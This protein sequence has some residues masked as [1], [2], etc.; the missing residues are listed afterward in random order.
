MGTASR[1]LAPRFVLGFVFLVSFALLFFVACQGEPGL[2]GPQG[3]KGDQGAQGIQGVQG[4]K[5]DPGAQGLQGLQG[6]AGPQG[7]QGPKGEPGE[8]A[9]IIAEGYS[10]KI[11]G[12]TIG[13]D[14]KPVVTFT[15]RDGKNQP[16]KLSDLDSNPG[17]IAAYIKED[18]ASGYTEYVNYITSAVTGSPYTFKGKTMQPVLGRITR[19]G[20]DSGGAFAQLAPGKY[21][22]TFKN[23]LPENYDATATHSIGM[24]TTR[25]AREF[26][27]N[28]VLDFVPAGGA[29]KTTRQIVNINNCNACHDKLAFHGGSRLDTKLCVLCHTSQN[30][31][32]ET[33][34]SVE[35]RTMV[36]RIHSGDR[37]QSVLSGTPYYIVGNRQT[38]FDFSGIGWPQDTRNC[39]TCHKD[40]PNADNYKNKP[41]VAACVS[42][43]EGIDP[44]KGEKHEV[45][46]PT[47]CGASCHKA[48]TGVEFDNSVVGA[49]VIP[50]A[51]SQL[52]GLKA[53][54][55]S[56]TNTA[57]GQKPVVTFKFTDNSGAV[58]DASTLTS[59]SAVMAHPTTDYAH[60]VADTIRSS[61][62]AFKGTAVGDG[63]FT[64]TMSQAVSDTGSMA[65][66]L[67]GYR[68]VKIKGKRGADLTVREGF[69][70]PV[71]YAAITD[72]KP[73]PR[74]SVVD[75]ANCNVCHK[76]LGTNIGVSL[77]G[78][79]RRNTETCIMCHNAN[80]NDNPTAAVRGAP[81]SLHFKFMVHSI[82]MG[83]DRAVATAF[84]SRNQV[85]T[86]EI[87]FPGIISNCQN[88]HKQGT[89]LLPLPKNLLPT[90]ITRQSTGEVVSVVQPIASACTA[91]H[92]APET[93]A[94]TEVMTSAKNVE[95][96][97]TCHAENREFAV[98]KM[99]ES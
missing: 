5:G 57:P 7:V 63:S 62:V 78:Q 90:T 50:E 72:A 23:T 61:T 58:V 12:V 18:K 96:C 41:N 65:V 86:E 32:P 46:A 89:N 88:C 74:R 69:M 99:H 29:V 16:L 44:L 67:Y 48:D 60:R 81:E 36:H 22:Y 28:D 6:V 10:A 75:V 1:S 70:N 30:V 53:T 68:D 87:E 42:C 82:H 85:Q 83:D 64:Y 4:S 37:L 92:A 17:F 14:R 47:E 34:N 33:G 77:H 21:T 25:G 76:V 95:S 3:P 11:D 13:A 59:L 73:E 80:F 38:V 31:D 49:H 66:S 20:A 9:Y 40:A 8:A 93:K 51:S 39:T 35:F 2:M 24:Y 56:V 15:V 55:V 26:V 94:H 43:H 91:C 71:A 97:A 19:P 45:S 52:A 54:I 84:G 98:S 27:V 79:S